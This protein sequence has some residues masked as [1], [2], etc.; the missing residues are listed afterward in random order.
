MP[1]KSWTQTCVM[2]RLM[3]RLMVVQPVLLTLQGSEARRCI[4]QRLHLKN[5][6]VCV[7]FW[8]SLPRGC[9]CASVTAGTCLSLVH[10]TMTQ[11]LRHFVGAEPRQL[12]FFRG[13]REAGD[14]VCV[15]VCQVD[16]CVCVWWGYRIAEARGGILG[17][18]M[19]ASSPNWQRGVG[20]R[21]SEYG[22]EG[23]RG[24]MEGWK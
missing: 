7:C 19:C 10:C 16:G 1:Q 15:C 5:V 11:A 13:G 17:R 8:E 21:V 6:R 4:R 9:W 14:S 24:E 20:G 12:F 2:S 3:L 23:W 22:W 18:S